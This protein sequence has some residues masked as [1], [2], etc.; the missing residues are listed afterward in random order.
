M[1]KEYIVFSNRLAGYLMYNGHILKRT[2]KSDKPNSTLNIY[3]FNESPELLQKVE[4]YKKL[5][6]RLNN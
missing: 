5:H 6:P 4:E 1:K 3:F 2:G